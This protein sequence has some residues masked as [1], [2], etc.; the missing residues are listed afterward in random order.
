[1]LNLGDAD[2]ISPSRRTFISSSAYPT[3]GA[4]RGGRRL[5]WPRR[6]PSRL[7]SLIE[8]HSAALIVRPGAVGDPPDGRAVLRSQLSCRAPAL[9]L[10]SR[11]RCGM[12]A[13]RARRPVRAQM[14]D[15]F[16]RSLCMGDEREAAGNY[17]PSASFRPV[18]KALGIA[19]G[20]GNTTGSASSGRGPPLGTQH[21]PSAA[22]A[23]QKASMLLTAWPTV[24]MPS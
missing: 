6:T 15:S 11:R 23:V 2:A 12:R 5:T 19:A 3:R 13:R 1:M 4:R 22:A 14:P 10:G 20:V 7:A 16:V 24:P 9:E 21:Q 17:R 18:L 8:K